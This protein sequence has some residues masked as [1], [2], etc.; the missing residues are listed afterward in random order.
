VNPPLASTAVGVVEPR[1]AG[2]ASGINSTFRQV[3][4]ATSVAA[5]GSILATKTAGATGPAAAGAFIEGLN[6]ILLISGLLAIVG[7]VASF[8]LIRRKDFVVHGGGEPSGDAPGGDKAGGA[9]GER[10]AEPAGVA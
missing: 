8:A 1:F 10:A 2:M 5:L 9:P 3:G 4:I 7:A 6:E